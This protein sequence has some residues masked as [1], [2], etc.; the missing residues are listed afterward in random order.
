MTSPEI[1]QFVVG[2]R[3]QI[4]DSYDMPIPLIIIKNGWE[5]D[6]EGKRGSK[7]VEVDRLETTA[8]KPKEAIWMMMMASLSERAGTNEALAAAIDF[9]RKSL[10]D[11]DAMWLVMRLWDNDDNYGLD[12]IQEIVEYLMEEWTA[13]PTESPS[14]STST[15]SRTGKRSTAHSSRRVA[16]S[17]S[18]R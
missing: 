17:T 15:P 10:P 12:D 6:D 5:L 4:D 8:R 18:T 9:V 1:K 16:V 7:Q 3:E 14:A 11:D 2:A 13:N